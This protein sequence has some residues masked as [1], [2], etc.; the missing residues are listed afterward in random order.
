MKENKFNPCIYTGK[1]PIYEKV[2]GYQGIT[3][4]WDWNSSKGKYERRKTGNQYLAYKKIQGL[5]KS[6][7]FDSFEKAKKW[8]ESP[9]LFYAEEQNEELTF[10]EVM[11]KYFEYKKT[12]VKA[13]TLETYE[14]NAS[15]LAFFYSLPMNQINARAVDA[16]LEKVKKAEYLALQHQT[17]LSYGH[18]LGLLRQVLAYY[19][20]YLCDSYQVP[21]KKRHNDDAIIDKQKY[22]QKRAEGKQRYIPFE[23]CEKFI[24]GLKTRGERTE[25]QW[26]YYVLGYLQLRTGMRIGEACALDFRDVNFETG[27]VYVSKTVQ[28]SRR[29][30]KETVISPSTKTGE[31]RYVYATGQIL[32][33][34]KDLGCKLGRTKGLIFSTTGFTPVPYRSVQY[35]YDAAFKEAGLKWRSTHI[36]RH[37]FATQF[38][39]LTSNQHALKGLLGHSDIRQT[40]HYGKTTETMI[41]SGFKAYEQRLMNDSKVASIAE[42]G[43]DRLGKQSVE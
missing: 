20:E 6:K 35:H 14:S 16:W 7:C 28:W 36:L 15:H 43:W 5:Q 26:L 11:D 33:L 25:H 18:E 31:S 2:P 27:E 21:I 37:S 4:I 3:S 34:L 1:D 8:R 23:D 13:S 32:G 12:K 40:D 17:R 22:F 38:L 19:S 10:K 41:L 39:E 29:K 42:T 30:G 9:N 24:N